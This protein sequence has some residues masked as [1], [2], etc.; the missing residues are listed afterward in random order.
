MQQICPSNGTVSEDL[1]APATLPLHFL[2][3][4]AINYAVEEAF[5]KRGRMGSA[6]LDV[7]PITMDPTRVL[8]IGLCIHDLH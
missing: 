4:F 5:Q 1:T 8:G 7:C 3:L 6:S 2:H